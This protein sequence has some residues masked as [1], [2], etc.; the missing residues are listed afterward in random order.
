MTGRQV[1]ASMAQSRRWI[2]ATR[3]LV[4]PMLFASV[5]LTSALSTAPL[6]ADTND[7]LGQA[8]N[9]ALASA[10][11]R[12]ALEPVPATGISGG[13]VVV[14]LV[15]DTGTATADTVDAYL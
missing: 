13:T 14:N 5:L 12:L 9:T 7:D 1:V 15:A 10:S 6:S 2:V 11:A 3:W 4:A 8:G